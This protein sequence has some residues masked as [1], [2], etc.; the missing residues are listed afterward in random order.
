MGWNGFFCIHKMDYVSLYLAEN[1]IEQELSSQACI[2]LPAPPWLIPSFSFHK[3]H[4]RFSFSFCLLAKL[5][6]IALFFPGAEDLQTLQSCLQIH[7]W[8]TCLS[9]GFWLNSLVPG[10]TTWEMWTASPHIMR[11]VVRINWCLQYTSKPRAARCFINSKYPYVN[12]RLCY[13]NP[14]KHKPSTLWSS[15]TFLSSLLSP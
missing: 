12:S 14:A 6:G 4:E 10:Y 9:F 11:D 5:H 15:M 8:L 13:K 2:F 7:N 3:P 1:L